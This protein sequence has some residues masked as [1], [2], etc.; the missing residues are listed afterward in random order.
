MLVNWKIEYSDSVPEGKQPPDYDVPGYPYWF[1]RYFKEPVEV[2]VLD[3]RS[4][5]WMEN[6]EKNKLHFY[7]IQSLR[8]LPKLGK[9]DIILSHGMQS[10]IVI[11]LFRRIFRNKAKHIIFDIGS[12][13]SAAESGGALKLQQFASKS[14][15]GLIYHTSSQI[16][17]YKKFFPWIVPK[18]KFIKFG[19]DYHF[20]EQEFPS[21]CLQEDIS[22]EDVKKETI[23]IEKPYMLCVGY[24]KRDWSTLC[25]AFDRIKEKGYHDIKL[26]LI[27]REKQGDHNGEKSRFTSQIET[28][29][30]IP[31]KQ[32]IHEIKGACFCVVPLE[33]FN[34]SFGQMTLL[35]QMSL[36]KAV[37]AA[38]VPSLVD[39]GEEEETLLYYTPKDDL[40]LSKRMECLLQSET[41]R[42]HLGEQAA[43]SV[44]TKY[45][46]QKMA[47][48]IE[49]FLSG[50]VVKR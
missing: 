5:S 48:S 44:R 35:Q 39:Y 18:S 10:G 19:T 21:N 49:Q 42:T 17:Y 16:N 29:P 25:R 2:T 27:G 13:N 24:A 14:I 40:D 28:M 50:Y 4:F 6:F 9:Y 20:L 15:D 45:N 36:G 38:R 41:L 7:I 43:N 26:K 46:E 31:M 8:A 33:T 34:Y 23:Q 12:F 47:E 30:Y 1:F 32:L 3:I 37:I 22:N 11:S